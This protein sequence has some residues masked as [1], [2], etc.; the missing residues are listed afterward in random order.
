MKKLI[1]VLIASL[2]CGAA[3]A[4]PVKTDGSGPVTTDGGGPVQTDF[5][6]PVSDSNAP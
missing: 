4:D 3:A 6:G 1:L 2:L 5:R